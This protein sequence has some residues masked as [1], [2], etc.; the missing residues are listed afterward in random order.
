M[1]PLLPGSLA[2]GL[3][4]DTAASRMCQAKPGRTTPGSI[5][6]VVINACYCCC[7]QV[8]AGSR[9]AESKGVPDTE[10]AEVIHEALTAERPRSRYLIGREAT[11]QMLLRRLL[12]DRAWDPLL[13]GGLKKLG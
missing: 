1:P 6:W 3:T 8:K 9:N 10:V 12:P 5:P 4:M 11:V 2:A 7:T 13:M